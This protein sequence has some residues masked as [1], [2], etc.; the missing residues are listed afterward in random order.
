MTDSEILHRLSSLRILVI[1][2]VMLDHYIVGDALRISPEAPVPVVRV[3]DEFHR[4]G[5]A[6]N[7]AMNLAGLGVA[8][9][10]FGVT[11]DDEAGRRLHG[12]LEA[13]GVRLEDWGRSTQAPTIVKSRIVARN[14]QVCR[15]DR[16]ASREH[17]SVGT[18]DPG[19]RTLLAEAVDSSDAVILSDY[20][21]GMIKQPLIGTVIEM[22]AKRGVL[23]AADPKP[24]QPLSYRGIGLLTPNRQE[25]VRM[26]GLEDFDLRDTVPLEEVCRLVHERHAP[27]ILAVTLGPEGMALSENG[28]ITGRFPAAVREVF[29]ISGAG[30]T[31]IATLTAALAAGAVPVEAARLANRAAGLVVSK[32]GTAPVNLDALASECPEH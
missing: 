24:S 31:V 22:A 7:V 18:L 17:Y 9:R 23:V 5:G 30:D 3:D 16:E 10:L 32:F 2:D 29:D 19:M 4:A 1:G 21:K 28:M 20:A 14:Q 12:I 8:T 13:S 25:A 27:E 11:G 15:I 26:A 6:A